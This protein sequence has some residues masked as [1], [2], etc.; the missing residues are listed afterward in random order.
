MSGRSRERLSTKE[1]L[2]RIC[3]EETDNARQLKIDELSLRQRENPSTVNQLLAQI[4]DLHD[5]INSLNDAGEY[6]DPETASSSGVS[7]VPSQPMSI[8][9]PRRMISRDSCLPHDTQNSM[10]YLKKRTCSRW[11]ILRILREAKEFGIIF[12]RIETK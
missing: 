9:S 12:L 8:P 5:K 6:Y 11:A 1:A 2:R 3:C 10:G 7:H 4:Q